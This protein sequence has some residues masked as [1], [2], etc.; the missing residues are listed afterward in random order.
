MRSTTL[1]AGRVVV[2][3]VIAVSTFCVVFLIVEAAA[4]YQIGAEPGDGPAILTANIYGFM[5]GAVGAISAATAWCIYCLR[6]PRNRIST[7]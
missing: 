2:G 3:L 1:I 6:R 4:L 5:A 7:T